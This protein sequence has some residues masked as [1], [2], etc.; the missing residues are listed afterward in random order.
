MCS[1]LL[2]I[3]T[4]QWIFVNSFFF[5]RFASLASLSMFIISYRQWYFLSVIVLRSFFSTR[6]IEWAALICKLIKAKKE[7][8]S[9]K[10]NTKLTEIICFFVFIEIAL[11]IRITVFVLIFLFFFFSCVCVCGYVW[12][13]FVLSCHLTPEQGYWFD[14]REI[15]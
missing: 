13:R 2:A 5:F 12:L 3:C 6:R 15:K 11:N 8:C 7:R 9:G 10:N 14:V 1:F 4:T